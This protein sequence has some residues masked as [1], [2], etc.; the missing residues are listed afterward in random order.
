MAHS[1][2]LSF[3]LE[4][5]YWTA[6]AGLEASRLGSRRGS[7]LAGVCAASMPIDHR[8][9]WQVRHYLAPISAWPVFMSSH[10]RPTVSTPF[11]HALFEHLAEPERAAREIWR[12][13][14]PSGVV[15]VRSPD[16]SGRLAGPP[17][18]EVDQ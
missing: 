6:A 11:F 9:N 18:T 5:M 15:G 1:F 3:G 10:L 16:W 2:V 7:R 14:K 4:P 17:I 13:L 8:W 12:V